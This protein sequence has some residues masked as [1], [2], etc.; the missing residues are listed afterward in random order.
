MPA[1]DTGILTIRASS[2]PKN[3]RTEESKEAER[4]ET[5]SQPPHPSGV[6]RAQSAARSPLGVP[7]RHLLQ[8]RFTPQAQPQLRAS[9][10]GIATGAGLPAPG[11]VPQCSGAPRPQT[12]HR[13]G[14]AYPPGPP[15]NGGDEPPPAGTDSRSVLRS[16]RM[17]SLYGSE[18]AGLVSNP[19]RDVTELFPDTTY[20]HG[21]GFLRCMICDISINFCVF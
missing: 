19:E 13:A 21:V 15:G 4:R 18:I 9:C 14:R 10:D 11:I 6:R 16:D 5:R 8:R 1:V 12:G 20:A 2:S 7:P 17:T 3:L